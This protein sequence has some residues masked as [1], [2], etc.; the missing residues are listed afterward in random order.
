MVTVVRIS[1]SSVESNLMQFIIKFDST[2]G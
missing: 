2:K 1:N